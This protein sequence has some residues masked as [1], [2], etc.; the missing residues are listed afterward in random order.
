M[1][2]LKSY[3]RRIIYTEEGEI[4]N[5][6]YIIDNILTIRVTKGYLNDVEN[7]ETGE[8]FPAIEDTAGQ[9]RHIEHWKNGLLHLDNG[10]PAVI[11]ID[12]CIQECWIN[13]R[14]QEPPKIDDYERP[15]KED[16]EK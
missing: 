7:P 8:I 3:Q 11:D 10:E 13:G 1:K 9:G 12:D 5:G 16:E 6:D 2:A 14:K 4:A 15:N